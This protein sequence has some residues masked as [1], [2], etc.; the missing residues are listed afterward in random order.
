[1]TEKSLSIMYDRALAGDVDRLAAAAGC[2]LHSVADIG[3]ARPLWSES[4]LVLLDPGALAHC[5]AAGLARRPGVVVLCRGEPP[6]ALWREAMEVGAERVLAL[7]DSEPSVVG[8][9]ADAAEG[10]TGD[11][12][13]IA[14]VG[15]RG[16][17][18]ASVLVAA[19][20]LLAVRRGERVLAVDCDPLGGGLDLLLGVE[21]VDG[22]RWPDLSLA[23]G[24]VPA[25]ALHAALPA[26]NLPAAAGSGPLTVLAC[27]RDGESP[28]AGAVGSVLDAGRRAGD[29][30]VCDLPRHLPAEASVALDRADLVVL[31]VPA[32]VRGCA[33][34]VPVARRLRERGCH[35]RAV[36]RGPAPGGLVPA[37]VAR[38]LS[39]PLLTAMRPAPR[40]AAALD[41]GRLPVRS[42]HGP[43]A[44]AAAVVLDAVG[45]RG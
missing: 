29:T 23:G 25:A 18:G 6:P 38:A 34:A 14:V 16:G 39:V 45:V 37:D 21:Q 27:G 12:R 43:L 20:G 33:A 9:L 42:T 24:R 32:E 11:G 7:P 13:V 10:A 40:L 36:V 3:E 44:R 17:A 31:V 30:V 26:A 8:V 4:P 5:G 35:V 2:A 22:L 1:V 41:A 15:G 28:A 19:V